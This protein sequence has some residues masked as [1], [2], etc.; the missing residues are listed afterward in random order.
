MLKSIRQ[1]ITTAGQGAASLISV[2]NSTV[3]TTVNSTNYSGTSNNALNLGGVVAAGYVVNTMSGSLTGNVT[4]SGTNTVFSSNVTVTGT[5]TVSTNA[6]LKVGTS[7]IIASG[8]AWM[9][10]GLMMNWGTTTVANSTG[11]A[12]TFANAFPTALFSFQLSGILGA[13]YIPFA[14]AHSATGLTIKTSNTINTTIYWMAV[15]N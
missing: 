4:F 10:N 3:N 8:Y 2:G 6:G 1:G 12:I 11:V 14:S 7:N 5:T 9:P 15:G 13:T